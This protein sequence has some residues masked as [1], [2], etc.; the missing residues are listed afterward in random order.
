[1]R[2]SPWPLLLLACGCAVFQKPAEDPRP[3]ASLDR[4]KSDPNGVCASMLNLSAEPWSVKQ[5]EP[6]ISV[7]DKMLSS[8]IQAC[9][10]VKPEADGPGEGAVVEVAF[11]F[12]Q[13]D[14]HWRP[15]YWHVEVVRQNGLV[16][17][18]TNLDAGRI[19]DGVCVLDV[20]NKEG[21]ATVA[22]PEPWQADRYRIRLTHVPTRK[23]VE[24]AIT[25]N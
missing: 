2:S 14:E 13:L 19:V 21:Y 3:V 18:A 16:V 12:P 8:N 15:E 11:T 7:G 24:L 25:L 1:M 5:R 6:T 9:A 22:L 17:L 4:L 20:C 23:R 10:R